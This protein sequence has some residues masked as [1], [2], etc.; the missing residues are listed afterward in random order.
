M[1]AMSHQPA[2]EPRPTSFAPRVTLM[3]VAGFLLFLVAAGLYV[4]PVLLEPAPPGAIVDYHK[5]RV[6]ARLEGKVIY[7]LVGSMLLAV[8]VG[9]RTLAPGDRRRP[10][11]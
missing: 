1:L 7:L 11:A 2:R 9:L 4:L 6:M 3:L 10:R 5:E 8:L